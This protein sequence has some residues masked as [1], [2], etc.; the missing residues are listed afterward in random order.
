MRSFTIFAYMY[1]LMISLLVGVISAWQPAAVLP[2]EE[3]FSEGVD[4][5]FVKEPLSADIMNRINGLSWKAES[6]LD[7]SDLRY[8]KIL[9][10]NSDGDY[11][12]GEMICNRDIADDLLDIFRKLFDAG[13]RIERMVLVDDYGADDDASMAA[14]NSSCFNTR[15][16][17]GTRKLSKHGLGMAVDINPLYNP[18]VKTV[19]GVVKVWPESARCY[20]FDRDARDDIPYMIDED[21]L[22][23]KLFKAKGFEWGG[24]WK[25]CK[26]YQ[27]FEK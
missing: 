23:C 6:P 14:N 3:V 13:Y 22:C 17:A 21:D 18:Y 19:G 9:H 8:L 5:F 7:L 4:A 27:H 25:S 11:Q 26:D 16:I 20:A 2:A 1:A 15:F 10:V 24:D 12:T